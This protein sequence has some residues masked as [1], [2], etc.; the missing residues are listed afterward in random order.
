[1]LAAIAHMQTAIAQR[2]VAAQTNMTQ[3]G[4]A[5][6]NTQDEVARQQR[7]EEFVK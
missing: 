6:A 3:Q 2:V 5:S 7:R 1:M 4:S